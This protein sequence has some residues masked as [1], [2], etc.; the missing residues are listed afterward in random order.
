MQ[1]ESPTPI[2]KWVIDWA[3]AKAAIRAR[4]GNVP[5][6]AELDRLISELLDVVLGTQGNTPDPLQA[7]EAELAAEDDVWDTTTAQHADTLAALAAQI[8]AAPVQPM[9][10]EKGRW[11]VDH[12]T[13]ADFQQAAK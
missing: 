8:E 12:Y 6:I 7:T 10:D 3:D 1:S 4:A 5:Q 9:F 11:L 13:E 2:S